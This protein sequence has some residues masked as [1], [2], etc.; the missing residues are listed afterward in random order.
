MFSKD[1]EKKYTDKLNINL[2]KFIQAMNVQT[3]LEK[4]FTVIFQFL[5]LIPF[6]IPLLNR[7]NFLFAF[8]CVMMQMLSC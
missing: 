7:N 2:L 5:L 6:L 8:T 4:T 3:D 1:D